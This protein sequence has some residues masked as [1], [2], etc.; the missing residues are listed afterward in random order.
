MKCKLIV[1]VKSGNSKKK[2]STQWKAIEV[3][4][5]KI[6]KKGKEKEKSCCSSRSRLGVASPSGLWKLE[7]MFDLWKFPAIFLDLATRIS[8]QMHRFS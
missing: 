2:K 4:W 7:N 3:K 8:R 1:M 5:V 6:A